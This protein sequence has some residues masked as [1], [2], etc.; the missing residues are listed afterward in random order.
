MRPRPAIV[1]FGA[2]VR[3]DGSPSTALRAR[4]EAALA[5]GRSLP[6]PLYVPTGG[7]GR[8]GRPEAVVMAELLADAGIAPGSILVEPTGRNTLRSACACARLLPANAPVYVATSTYHLPRCV[9][10]LRL[11][12]MPARPGRTPPGPASASWRKRWF[13]RLRE[14]PAVPVDAALLLLWRLRRIAKF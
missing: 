4:V 5:L 6:D 14:A 12:G 3:P 7:Q 8:H 1:I 13:W 9:L 10:L 2:A 11:L